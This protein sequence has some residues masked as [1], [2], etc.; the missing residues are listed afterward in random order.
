VTAVCC[1]TVIIIIII[2]I[3][4]T[5][6][7]LQVVER[8]VMFVLIQT[9]VPVAFTVLYTRLLHQMAIC[10]RTGKTTENRKGC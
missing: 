4:I 10:M 5:I 2:I 8:V 7:Q 1:A 9:P 6:F 3:V